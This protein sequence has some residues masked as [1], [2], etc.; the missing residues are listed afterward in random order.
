MCSHPLCTARL[1]SFISPLNPLWPPVFAS[2]DIVHMP[3]PAAAAAAAAKKRRAPTSGLDSSAP[4]GSAAPSPDLSLAKEALRGDFVA[5]SASSSSTALVARDTSGETKGHLAFQTSHLTL[6]RYKC[7]HAACAQGAS[8][9][10][11]Q[12]AR[13][14]EA[15]EGGIRPHGLGELCVCACDGCAC[16]ACSASNCH[17]SPAPSPP[18]PPPFP[19]QVRCVN[20]DVS[21][22]W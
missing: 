17:T 14:L 3:A 20:V 1:C 22:E 4:V 11:A 12:M 8:P 9:E 15:E 19:L 10:P 16:A 5:A 13:S 21:N 6:C 18:P 2:C 7:S